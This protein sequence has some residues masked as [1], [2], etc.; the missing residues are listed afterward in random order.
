MRNF[1]ILLLLSAGINTFAQKGTIKG[2][3]TD[4]ETNEALPFV[5]IGLQ[6]SSFG[7]S[8]DI[9]GSYTISNI[10]PGIYNLSASFVG[11][12]SANFTEI[13]VTS[14][15]TLVVNIKLTPA[16]IKLKEVEIS[17]SRF[18]KTEE[19]PLSKV[20]IRSA[21][22]LRNPGGNRDISKVL[23]SFPGVASSVSFRNDLIVRGGAPNENRFYLDGIEVPNINHF[24]T[25]GSSG[26]PVGMINVN[27][28]DEV[29]FY[30]GAFP[31]ARGNALSSVLEFKQRNG[32]PDR[33]ITNVMV[34]SSD[35]ALTF[36]GPVGK[37]IDY[38]FSARRSYLQ[39][40]FTALRLPFLPTY[41]DFQYK[42]NYK[43]DSK[44]TLTFIGLGAIDQFRLNTTVNNG[45]S[46][47][48]TIER[49]KY[50]LGYLPVNNQWNYTTG[51][52]YTRVGE[53]NNLLNVVISRNHLSNSAV[54]YK[55][56]VEA[57][58]NV[59]LD[60]QSQEIENKLRI[61][62][63]KRT[64]NWKITYGLNYEFATYTNKTFNKLS[65]PKGIK[66][67]NFNSDLNF[68]K[69][70]LFGQASRSFFN[71]RLSM[72]FGLRSDFNDYSAEM[73]N[74]LEQISPRV[75]G[76]YIISEKFNFNFSTGRYFQLPSYT[77]LGFRDNNNDLVN[78]PRVKYISNTHYTSGLDYM[79][80][81]NTKVSVEGFFKIYNNYPFL[82]N[83]QISLANLG[84]DF[85]VIGN[86]PTASTSEGRSYGTELLI[87][88]SIK[89]GI[90][91][92]L[93]YTL[94]RSEFKDKNGQYAPSSWDNMHILSLTGG[95]QFKKNW[96]VGFRFRFSGGSPY[97]PYDIGLSS[98]RAVWEITRMGVFD[99]NRIN[100]ERL[101]AAHGLDVRIDKKWYY[102]SWSANIYLDIQNLYNKKVS[103]PPFLNV[104]Q[105]GFGNPLINQDNPAAY[106][107]YL[108]PNT[109]GTVLPSIGLMIEF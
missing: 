18:E 53:K 52:K 41:N 81:G 63:V 58:Q 23:Q 28:I 99:W 79:P 84:G 56:N 46:D 10:T 2:I 71:K 32:N 16:K 33:L 51:A 101:G 6:G 68:N 57:A 39:F 4:A 86:A 9:N 35:V 3:I 93:A 1:L 13:V 74:P 45:I 75:S 94:V 77:V 100:S 15:K 72:S 30:S 31:A 49:N 91:G 7:A 44:S 42:V 98:Q 92:I 14:T 97:T 29:E 105:D 5:N 109:T 59:I 66:E 69:Y 12:E 103:T 20:S 37:K 25:Q 61:E 43:I 60:Y 8:S 88:R 106:Q 50:I 40:L 107:T 26:G 21:E 73:A 62:N 104:R 76:S 78:K 87:Q 55:N 22:I 70:G 17:V 64:G 27:F 47:S 19:S 65:T 48:S 11:Y 34:G 38:I 108:I 82:L 89:K 95:K 80:D 54:K 85:G 96:E 83:E 24:A 67:I 90:Y 102:K 36:D